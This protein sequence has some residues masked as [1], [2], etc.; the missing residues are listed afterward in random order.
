MTIDEAR[1]IGADAIWHHGQPAQAVNLAE[2]LD[3]AGQ[4]KL[5]TLI[6]HAAATIATAALPLTDQ[7]G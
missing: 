5:A 4:G 1:H 3:A 7:G 2:I 6:R